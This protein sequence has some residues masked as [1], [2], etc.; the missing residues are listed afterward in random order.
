MKESIM[1]DPSTTILRSDR[2]E[3]RSLG[4]GEGG[5]LLHLDTAAYH[6]VNEVGALIWTLIEGITFQELLHE[7]RARL[8]DIPPGFEEDI[9][10]FI[11]DLIDRNLVSYTSGR[12]EE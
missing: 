4:D 12:G 7:L 11:E 3:Y 1:L 8:S 10:D 6:G 9:A 2:V 5:V